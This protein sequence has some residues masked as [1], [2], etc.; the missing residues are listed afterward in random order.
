MYNMGVQLFMVKDHTRYLGWFADHTWKNNDKWYTY[1]PI[2]LCILCLYI[3][4]YT[5]RTVA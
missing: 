2:L 1:P 5:G 4:N 3:D